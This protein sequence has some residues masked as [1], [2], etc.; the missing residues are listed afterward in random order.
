MWLS[1]F[2]PSPQADGGYDVADYRDV[3]PRF[4]TLADADAL[5]AKAQDLG[6]KVIVDLV[7]NHSSDEHPWFQARASAAAPGVARAGAL[8]LPRRAGRERRHGRRTTGRRSS[9]VRPGPGSSEPDGRPG[10]WYLHL[11]D[12]KQPDWDW[13]NP[14]VQEEFRSILRFWLDRG[15][16]GFRVDVAHG[17]VKEDGLPDHDQVTALLDALTP[18]SAPTA[19]GVRRRRRCGTRKGSTRSTGNGAEP[20][21]PTPRRNASSARRRG[22]RH[23]SGSRCTCVPTRCTRRSPS[24]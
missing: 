11:F 8:P 5:L 14:D 1:P 6:L 2:Y 3:D 15:V 22:S 18:R 19:P 23:P 4:G 20:W 17:L 9:A 12:A 16:A 24:T 7:P 13:T 21:T 10:Q